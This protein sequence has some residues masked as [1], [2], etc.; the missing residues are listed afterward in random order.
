MHEG[1]Y[2]E[3][4]SSIIMLTFQFRLLHGPNFEVVN[5]FFFF[6]QL[7]VIQQKEHDKSKTVK[8]SEGMVHCYVQKIG[9][10]VQFFFFSKFDE[11]LKLY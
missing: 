4:T 3:D 11:R 10:T 5:S 1:N 2:G 7:L 8:V 9:T 6:G